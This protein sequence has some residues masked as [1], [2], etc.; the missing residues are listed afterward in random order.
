MKNQKTGLG[1]KVHFYESVDDMLA[2]FQEDVDNLGREFLPVLSKFDLGNIYDQSVLGTILT[3]F[4]AVL[5]VAAEGSDPHF[6]DTLLK[7]FESQLEYLRTIQDK[8][9]YFEK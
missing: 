1:Q 7:D 5:T 2:Q 9:F 8:L 3:L 6:K 4:T